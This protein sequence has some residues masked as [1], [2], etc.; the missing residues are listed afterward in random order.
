MLDKLMEKKLEYAVLFDAYG[1]LLTKK[2][3]E[4]L[5]LYFFDDLSYTEIADLLS[6]SKQAVHDAINKSLKKLNNFEE[7][8]GYINLKTKYEELIV[9]LD[10]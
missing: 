10:K 2:Q 7:N 1:S 9:N 4:I 6:I 5:N 3:R 8:I